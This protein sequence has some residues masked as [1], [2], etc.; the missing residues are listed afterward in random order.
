MKNLKKV[1]ALVLAVVMIMGVVTVASAKTYKDVDSTNTYADAIDALSSLKILDGFEDG[2]FKADRTFNRAQAAKIVA[3]VHNAAT[4]GKI[5][6]QDAISALYS[7]AQNPFVDCNS[8][9]ALP[10]INYCRITGLADGMTATT[11][12]PKRE[13]TGVQWL[14]LML[15]TLNFDTAKEGYTG[16]GWDVNVLNRAN[17]IGLLEGLP[18]GWKAIDNV[19]RGE[20]AQILFNALSKYLV[21]YGQL[22]K[23]YGSTNAGTQAKPVKASFVSNEQVSATG[24]KLVEK[25]GIKIADSYDVYWRPV[26]TWTNVNT[27][28]TVATFF[29]N[30]VARFT[31]LTS[32]CDVLKAIGLS[33]AST[34]TIDFEEIFVNGY[35]NTLQLQPATGKL[36]YGHKS[37]RECQGEFVG[38]QGV[39]TQVFKMVKTVNGKDVVSYRITE[40]VSF[41]GHVQTVA[42][43]T[44]PSTSTVKF[45]EVYARKGHQTGSWFLTDANRDNHEKLSVTAN[46]ASTAFAAGDYALVA[47]SWKDTTN[48]GDGSTGDAG[49]NGFVVEATKAT[50]TVATLNGATG[51][52]RS[53]PS[54]TRIDGTYVNDA[55][56]FVEGY[57]TAHTIGNSGT[58]YVFFYDTYGNV[59]GMLPNVNAKNYFVVENI[60]KTYEAGG[61][62]TINS[63]LVD[64]EKATSDVKL[65]KVSPLGTNDIPTGTTLVKAAAEGG[66]DFKLDN[67]KTPNTYYYGLIY[68]FADGAL[69]R[70]GQNTQPYGTF[71]HA[72]NAAELKG[73]N[74]KFWAGAEWEYKLDGNTKFLVQKAGSGEYEI[75][76]GYAALPALTATQMDYV[77]TDGTNNTYCTMVYLGGAVYADESVTGYVTTFKQHAWVDGYEQVTVYAA[78]EATTVLVRAEDIGSTEFTQNLN[79]LQTAGTPGVYTFTTKVAKDG[80]VYAASI[81]A[82]DSVINPRV[83]TIVGF[84]ADVITLVDNDTI[85][86]TEYTM[87]LKDVKIYDARGTTLTVI[88]AETLQTLV[89]DAAN[90]GTPAKV[91]VKVYSTGNANIDGIY[92]TGTIA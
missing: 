83:A 70:E 80:T 73:K 69:T 89:S 51:E 36:G 40:V 1:L 30:E 77:T 24:M 84:G 8:S 21:E 79:A 45:D 41:L 15:T 66:I 4:N 13:L 10:F 87:G 28:K 25:M 56:A 46:L 67:A 37:N 88:D 85:A 61:V 42:K 81:T 6:D 39:L 91:T 76:T 17:E 48:T 59:I 20:A 50:G 71:T 44:H 34:S 75:Y 60:N 49:G 27:N 16:T 72:K 18:E 35:R 38:G 2:E 92:V 55:W 90:L 26:T 54:Q 57:K 9:W 12:A 11:Y 64:F 52:Y 32:Y 19:K 33:E 68:S 7:N 58:K 3:I 62:Y 86:L 31:T 65:T 78:G 63:K 14:K 5:K 47:M 53:T 74:F 82:K 23:S 43:T 22:I 29:K